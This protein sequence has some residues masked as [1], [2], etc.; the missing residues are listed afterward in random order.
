MFTINFSHSRS[1]HNL[2]DDQIKAFYETKYDLTC[3]ECKEVFATY[4][5]KLQHAREHRDLFEIENGFSDIRADLPPDNK[6]LII[7]PPK[8]QV[9]VNL[10]TL[11]HPRPNIESQYRMVKC[12]ICSKQLIAQSLDYHRASH[13]QEATVPCRYC[14]KKFKGLQQLKAHVRRNHRSQQCICERCGVA[15]KTPSELTLHRKWHDDP[16]PFEC[17]ICGKRYRY[18][19]T[20]PIHMRTAHTKG[21]KKSKIIF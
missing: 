14:D 10:N 21:E 15:F 1:V 9:L 4:N 19:N 3:N 6:S 11:K 12:D 16:Y 18:R 17:E 7:R 13:V 8:P 20:L 2:S 5:A